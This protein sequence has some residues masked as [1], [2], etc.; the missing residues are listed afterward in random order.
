VSLLAATA[1]GGDM[2]HFHAGSLDGRDQRV[3]IVVSRF[4]ELFTE[5]LL[6]GALDC[7]K[8]HGAEDANLH[9]IR[10]PGSFEVPLAAKTLAESG[11][12]DAVICLAAVI[13]GDTPHFDYVAAEIAKGIA[14]VGF[15]T[16]VPVSF[17]VLTTDTLEQAVERSG[18]KAGNKG[19]DAAMS[20]IEMVNVLRSV[21]GAAARRPSRR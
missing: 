9:V 15:A 19:W 21:R 2:P 1:E 3:A 18:A 16:G 13:R 7:L 17:G 20:A 6:D 4:N 5:R 8:R 12:F 14:Q 11:R 10:V